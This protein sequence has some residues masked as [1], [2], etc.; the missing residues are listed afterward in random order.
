MSTREETAGVDEFPPRLTLCVGAVVQRGDRV[1]FVRQTYGENLTGVWTLPWGFVQGVLP[2]GQPDPPH[3]AALREALEEGGIT[4]AVEG[5][6]GIQNHVSRD[7]EPR[8]YLLFLCRHVSGTPTPDG[9][10]TDRAAYVSL[11]ELDALDEPV[12]GFCLWLARRVLRGEHHLIPP[13]A[14]NPYAPHLAFF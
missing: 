5:L 9:V 6:L 4:A 1:L 12:D 10:E 14:A 3:V 13:E 11:A 2:D 8:V 7:G